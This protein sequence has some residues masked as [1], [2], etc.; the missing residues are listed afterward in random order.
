MREIIKMIVVL[1]M[2]ATV[3]GASLSFINAKTAGRIKEQRFK[4][5][6]EPALTAILPEYDNDL[7]KDTFETMIGEKT[8]IVYPAKKSGVLKAIAFE[9]DEKSY[10]GDMSVMVAMD[11][12]EKRLTGARVTICNDTPG[13]G[14]KVT[15]DEAFINQFSDIPLYDQDGSDHILS[16]KKDGG[17]VDAITGATISSSSVLRAVNSAVGIMREHAG[18]I[19]EK[20]D[21]AGTVK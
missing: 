21:R 4:Y 9:I 2:I 10:G 13:L 18:E 1:A 19:A 6:K 15:T 12:E 11:L 3:S 17:G 14:L 5:L 7:V 20:A 16:L 8:Y